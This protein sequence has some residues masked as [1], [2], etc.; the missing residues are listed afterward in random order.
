MNKLTKAQENVYNPLV[1]IKELESLNAEL[2][3]ALKE[4][5]TAL[6]EYG[7]KA[8]LDYLCDKSRTAIAK[9]RATKEQP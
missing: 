1:R 6:H 4:V 3:E 2:V 8:D 9:A 7:D 5:A